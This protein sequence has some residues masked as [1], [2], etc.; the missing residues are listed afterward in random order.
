VAWACGVAKAYEVVLVVTVVD[1]L[2]A[3]SVPYATS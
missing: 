1:V 2:R 3:E